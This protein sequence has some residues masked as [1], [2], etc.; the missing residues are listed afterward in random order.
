MAADFTD[1]RLRRLTGLGGGSTN[2]AVPLET[3]DRV[4]LFFGGLTISED[5]QQIDA[6][7]GEKMKKHW[8]MDMV[9][10]SSK[11][12]RMEVQEE[13]VASAMTRFIKEHSTWCMQ[14]AVPLP[15]H[16]KDMHHCSRL[17]RRYQI[18]R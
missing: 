18:R 12:W 6:L 5:L 7:L 13:V 8:T 15:T 10:C 2:V 16:T 9:N 11:E 3:A 14:T 17:T 1:G 4:A